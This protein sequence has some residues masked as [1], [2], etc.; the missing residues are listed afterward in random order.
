MTGQRVRR[1]WLLVPAH[2]AD[3]LERLDTFG[4]DVIVLD[5]EDLVHDQR[6]YAARA[7]VG[8]APKCSCAATWS[9]CMPISKHPCGADSRASCY[10]R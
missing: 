5:L 7:S 10:P 3:L 8:A 4:A 6:K 1:S 9:C 2:R